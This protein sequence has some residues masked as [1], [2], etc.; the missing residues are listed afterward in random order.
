MKLDRG[1]KIF[2]RRKPGRIKQGFLGVCLATALFTSAAANPT[3]PTV[4]HG[5]V[6][7]SP[8][9]QTQIQQLTDKAIV[10]WQSFSIGADESVRILQPSLQSV[11]LNRVV[12]QDPSNILGTL[13][14]NG[15]VFLI[16]PNGI[17]FGPHSV[18]NVGGL[19][20]STLGLSNE[21]FIAGNYRF[22]LED[23]SNLAP[24]INQGTIRISDAGY[25][26]LTGPT[27]I[28]EGVIVAKVGKVVLGAGERATLNLDGRDLIHFALA[29]QVSEGITLLTPGS[30]SEALLDILGVA[31][32]RRA[33]QLVRNSDGSIHLKNSSGT[34]VQ[35][36]TVRADGDSGQT[37]GS[38]LIDSSDLSLVTPNSVT[39]A[40]GRGDNS[41]GGGER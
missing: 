4:S 13:E 16:N 37:A 40:S 24:V 34:A 41:A 17:L 28:N 6:Q 21:D 38:I 1:F 33:D 9:L 7:I 18:V 36:G 35:A 11:I 5:Q 10:D 15:N 23:A 39:S 26:V 19:V 14:A 31:A 22:N 3:G 8:G 20:A 12:G 30:V 27:V 32:N 29:D 2:K 25:A